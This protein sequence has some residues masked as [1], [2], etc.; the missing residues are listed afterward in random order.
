MIGQI[1]F[2]ELTDL[3]LKGGAVSVLLLVLVLII[4]GELWP[5][6]QVDALRK[7]TIKAAGESG[8]AV[9]SELIDHFEGKLLRA[10]KK[11]VRKLSRAM[12]ARRRSRR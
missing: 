12:A 4:R 9:A 2:G 7:D 6:H 3:V 11:Q 1:T 8:K 10:R 5:K